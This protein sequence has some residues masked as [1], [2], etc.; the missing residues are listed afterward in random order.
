MT[1]SP[2]PREPF[3]PVYWPLVFTL[4]S[5]DVVVGFADLMG[6]PSTDPTR[7]RDLLREQ[8]IEGRRRFARD[9]ETGTLDADAMLDAIAKSLGNAERDGVRWWAEHLFEVGTGYHRD[10]SGWSDLLRTCKDEPARW[11]RLALPAE[12]SDQARRAFVNAQDIDPYYQRRAEVRQGRLS[13]WDLHMY[14][15]NL[16]D[17]EDE[18]LPTGPDRYLYP[19]VMAAREYAWWAWL[20]ERL[21]T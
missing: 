13:D 10:L 21:D 18:A 16:F 3:D 1:T 12:V 15:A 11:S 9:P 8:I 2:R 14:A 17:D 7:L 5:M 19:T 20:V 4:L 6:L